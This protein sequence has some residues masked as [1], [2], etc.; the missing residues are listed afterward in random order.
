LKNPVALIGKHDW[1]VPVVFFAI[2]LII[3]LRIYDDYGVSWDERVQR[4]YGS[5]V[6]NYI[7]EGDKTLFMNRHRYYGPAFEFFLYGLERTLGLHDSRDVYFMR[8]LITF[9]AFWAGTF[10]F[11]LLC[12]REFGSWKVGLLGASFLVLSPRI[13]AHSLYNSKDVPFMTVFIIGIYTLLLY[14]EHRSLRGAVIHG[15]IC[16]LLIDIR[17]VGTLLVAL[18]LVFAGYEVLRSRRNMRAFK[19]TLLS[20][21]LYLLTVA[22][23][24]VL[25]WPTLWRDPVHNFIRVFEGMRNFP[26]EATILYMG[27]YVWSTE[28]PWHYLSVWIAITNPVSLIALFFVGLAISI[29]SLSGRFRSPIRRKRSGLLIIGWL[30]LPLAYS[31]VSSAVLYD[32]WRHAFFVYPALLMLSLAGLVL[33]Y[34]ITLSKLSRRA[35][36]AMVAVL[37]IAVGLDAALVVAFMVRH[38]PH[39]N[40]YFNRIVGGTGGAFGRFEM[41]YWGLSYRKGLEY[42]LEHDRGSRIPI[43]A[44]TAPGRYNADVI[45]AQERDRLVFVTAGYKAR[46]YVTTFRWERKEGPPGREVYAV[47]IDGVP[48]LAVYSL[49]SGL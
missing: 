23:V 35:G 1:F 49:E 18:T 16:G 47:R 19:R 36:R 15:A 7:T 9:L 31:V 34:R 24:T 13:F 10:F 44:A 32:G 48:I 33:L 3:G 40:V 4:Q 20:L 21:G 12:K 27:T 2:L 5:E 14:L 22:G 8:H 42:I 28:L 37:C 17:I 43:K 26:W 45:E 46:Y 25:L 41:D 39:Q 11:Y 30:F 6:G 29:L 38:H